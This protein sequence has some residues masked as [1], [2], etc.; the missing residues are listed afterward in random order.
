MIAILHY[1]RIMFTIKLNYFLTENFAKKTG[2]EAET[3]VF[4]DLF[5]VLQ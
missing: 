4:R 1:E 2:K 5:P 3:R